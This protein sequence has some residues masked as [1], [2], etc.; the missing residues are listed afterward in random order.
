MGT[1]NQRKKGKI[2]WERMLELRGKNSEG[3]KVVEGEGLK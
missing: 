3:K 2:K 1:E